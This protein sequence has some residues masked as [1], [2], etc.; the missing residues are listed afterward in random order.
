MSCFD[1]IRSIDFFPLQSIPVNGTAVHSVE[2]TKNLGGNFDFS[3]SQPTWNPSVN[4]AG[5]NLHCS[6]PELQRHLS[7]FLIS[8]K[9]SWPPPGPIPLHTASGNFR[10]IPPLSVLQWFPITLR[11]KCQ[12]LTRTPGLSAPGL[13]AA[14]VCWLLLPLLS[15]SRLLGPL[16]RMWSH[17]TA[18]AGVC[19]LLQ[20]PTSPAV[21]AP[22]LV[23]SLFIF[24][25]SVYLY[26]N[27]NLHVGVSSSFACLT[28]ECIRIESKEL[29]FL[30]SL[31]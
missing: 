27:S 4:P 30:L 8:T 10:P 31:M 13:S 12:I 28:L 11:I 7:P 17:F 1:R 14:P 23:S 6:S 3:L 26:L 18:V 21:R 25:H 15:S 29:A 20:P 16:A 2:H 19:L 5:S 22:A 9:T 24:L